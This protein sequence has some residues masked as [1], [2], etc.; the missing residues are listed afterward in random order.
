MSRE[1]RV[2][3]LPARLQSAADVPA[4]FAAQPIGT[5]A[6]LLAAIQ[7]VAP[8]TDISAQS[9][10][11]IEG[12]DGPIEVELGDTEPCSAI[13]L[14]LGDDA[15]SAFIVHDLLEQLGLRA[16]D[17]AAP[18]GLFARPDDPEGLVRWHQHRSRLATSGAA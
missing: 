10:C 7:R 13:T 2:Q 4:D 5:R 17:P 8:D 12:P 9:R 3:H 6:D 11:R 14:R 1:L 18:N 16:L 15:A